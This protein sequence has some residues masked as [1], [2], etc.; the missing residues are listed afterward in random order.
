[1]P[2]TQRHSENDTTEIHVAN[3]GADKPGNQIADH[4]TGSI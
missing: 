3:H 1:M 2:I 4:R